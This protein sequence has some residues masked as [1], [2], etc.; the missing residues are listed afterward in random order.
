ME[1]ENVVMN[2][3][4]TILFK[5]GAHGL[6]LFENKQDKHF[7]ATAKAVF[8]VCGA[9][10]TV[11]AVVG[12]CLAVGVDLHMAAELA[13]LAAGHVVGQIGTATCSADQL[14]ALL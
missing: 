12:A 9:G 14:R 4:P 10:D 8:D 11:V 1:A 3:F 2:D 13:N 6:T 7:P 5:E